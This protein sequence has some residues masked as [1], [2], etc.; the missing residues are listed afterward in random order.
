[1]MLAL[2]TAVTL[3]LW[4]FLAYSKAYSAMRLLAS[5]VISLMLWT[6][7]STIWNNKKRRSFRGRNYWRLCRGTSAGHGRCGCVVSVH[8]ET[9]IKAHLFRL[10]LGPPQHDSPKNKQIKYALVCSCLQ[11][12]CTQR[13]FYGGQSVALQDC[14]KECCMGEQRQ[15]VRGKTQKRRERK[16]SSG[17]RWV[18]DHL[19]GVTSLIHWGVNCQLRDLLWPTS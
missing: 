4:L 6:T 18:Q 1:M 2:W 11:H 5:S 8:S 17:F 13:I 19:Q 7:P 3:V 9:R 12:L 10:H 15:D 14:I 16:S